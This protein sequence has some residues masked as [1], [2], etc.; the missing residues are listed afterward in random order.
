MEAKADD[1][2]QIAWVQEEISLESL[3]GVQKLMINGDSKNI[4]TTIGGDYALLR[5]NDIGFSVNGQR[6][7]NDCNSGLAMLRM[8]S[9]LTPK[10]RFS[11]KLFT[12]CAIKTNIRSMNEMQES[13]IDGT[14]R[15][16]TSN[17]EII[18]YTLGVAKNTRDI[19]LRFTTEIS[20]KDMIDLVRSLKSVLEFFNTEICVYQCVA[21]IENP[22]EGVLNKDVTAGLI[23]NFWES[24]TGNRYQQVEVFSG[25]LTVPA[26]IKY[27]SINLGEFLTN[28][29]ML[30]SAIR[31]E[32][33]P[34]IYDGLTSL[35]LVRQYEGF[36]KVVNDHR[37]MQNVRYLKHS[38][39]LKG[40]LS[41]ASQMDWILKLNVEL[42]GASKLLE[43]NEEMTRFIVSQRNS[44]AHSQLQNSKKYQ[45]P[46]IVAYSAVQSKEEVYRKIA[47]A[48][49]AG[50]FNGYRTGFLESCMNKC[51]G[52]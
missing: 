29:K 40:M 37:M 14:R 26:E 47:L 36:M 10:I 3:T 11:D 30:F 18:R 12:E 6:I 44:F 5:H 33:M 41:G 39:S 27:L 50:L 19:Q 25:I 49:V 23:Y 4:F 42:L 35:L 52:K 34:I 15:F 21:K 16:L 13:P 28:A 32:A 2:R 48:L 24:E 8:E 51:A 45:F 17:S 20:A 1:T 7:Y 46:E 31:L 43:F 22:P 9:I 38:K